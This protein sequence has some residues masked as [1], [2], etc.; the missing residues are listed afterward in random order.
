M[1]VIN[2]SKQNQ[3]IALIRKLRQLLIGM[4]AMYL[5]NENCQKSW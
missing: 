2:A 4:S 3:S 5:I 1:S